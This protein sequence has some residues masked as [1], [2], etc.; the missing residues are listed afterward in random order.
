MAFV[1]HPFIRQY[2]IA[3]ID[4]HSRRI[5]NLSGFSECHLSFTF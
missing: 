3:D 2:C 5:R 1:L 4:F